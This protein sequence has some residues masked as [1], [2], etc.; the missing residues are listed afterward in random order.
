MDGDFILQ[1]SSQTKLSSN[2]TPNLGLSESHLSLH[3]HF[4]LLTCHAKSKWKAE[5]ELPLP[6]PITPVDDKE[7]C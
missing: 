6:I 7:I 3:E 2:D 4:T 5:E 1:R